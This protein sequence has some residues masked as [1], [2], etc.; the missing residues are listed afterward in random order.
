[1]REL[2]KEE[3]NK[4]KP[5]I[6]ETSYGLQNHSIFRTYKGAVN[7]EKPISLNGRPYKG[8]KNK[9]TTHI[10]DIVK[11]PDGR[12]ALVSKQLCIDAG[13]AYGSDYI[14]ESENSGMEDTKSTPAPDKSTYHPGFA[15]QTIKKDKART[16][17]AG[18]YPWSGIVIGGIS[19]LLL[20]LM[21]NGY[22][23]STIMA[24]LNFII[25]GATVSG[26]FCGFILRKRT[27]F[28][29]SSL[30]I[31]AGVILS[32]LIVG[33]IFG[34]AYKGIFGGTVVTILLGEPV[35]A[36]K[37]GPLFGAFLG[38]VFGLV[39]IVI[40]AVFRIRKKCHYIRESIFIGAL[41]GIIFGVIV[42]KNIDRFVGNYIVTIPLFIIPI[43]AMSGYFVSNSFRTKTDEPTS[44]GLAYLWTI[45]FVIIG[46]SSYWISGQN[47]SIAGLISFF[48]MKLILIIRDWGKNKD[49]V[50][51]VFSGAIFMAIIGAIIGYI[52]GGLGIILLLA[53]LGYG[54]DETLIAEKNKT[55][56][57]SSKIFRLIQ[58]YHNS[59]FASK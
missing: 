51:V 25:I 35:D 4:I 24:P 55:E 49:T 21:L 56:K 50:D 33:A 9:G 3:Y 6:R 34:T 39:F 52:I 48:I 18:T 17:G 47:G 16:Y 46:V 10:K 32:G 59:F 13:I 36:L 53:I 8:R 58:R 5:L 26:I 44:K 7:C 42:T 31:F 22:F 2:T 28:T 30:A 20:A 11:L 38:T 41:I 14:P 54:H 37:G 43:S 19:G 40:N 29:I 12:F 1:M 45:A 23:E 57:N 27:G 15:G